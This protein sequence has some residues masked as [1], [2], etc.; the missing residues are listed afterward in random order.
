M[1]FFFAERSARICWSKRP[2]FRDKELVGISLSDRPDGLVADKLVEVYLRDGGI[3]W[4]LIHIEVQAQRDAN[5]AR[6]V[7][8]YNYRINKEYAQP[9][10]SLVILADEDPKWRP[11]TYHTEVFGTATTF[12]FLTAKLLDYAGRDKEL[13][14]SDNPFALVTLAHLRT[15]QARHDPDELYAAKLHLTKLLYQHDWHKT[16]II[17][18]FK[19]IEWMMVLPAAHQQRYWQAVLKL[20]REQKMQWISPMEQSF[21][22]RGREQG[23]KE[24]AIEILERQLAQRFGPLSKTDRNKLAK[25]SLDQLRRWSDRMS[26]AESLQQVLD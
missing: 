26:Q 20:E 15:Q 24:G 21:M 10:A 22:D 12:S 7:Y 25:A 9:V 3:Q 5:F 13:E 4:M 8:D 1:S 2:R 14:A 18:L 17:M 19:V 11:D 16:R 23:R 6:R